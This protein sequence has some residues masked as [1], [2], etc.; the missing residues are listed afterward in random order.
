MA[1]WAGCAASW[2]AGLAAC[3][4]VLPAFSWAAAGL[5]TRLLPPEGRFLELD[6][7]R[8]HVL[9]LGHG[10]PVLLIHGLGG[11]I[12]NFTHSLTARLAGDF[13]LVLVDRPGA[14][15]SP[16]RADAAGPRAQ[17]ALLARLVAALALERPLLVGHSLGGAVALAMALHHPD[18]VGGLA[19]LAPLTHPETVAPAP[20][21]LLAIRPPRLRALAAWT[22]GVPV[23]MLCG[24]WISRRIFAPDVPARN[25]ALAGGGLLALRP[26]SIRAAIADLAAIPG[27]LAAM[28]VLYD[29]LAALPVGVLF[30]RQDRILDPQRHGSA[31]QAR[32]PGCE[33]RLVPG[34]HMLPVSAPDA[35]AALIRATAARIPRG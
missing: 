2:A 16:R 20:F 35:C 23:G 8:L 4:A 17:A 30:G 15:H 27:D 12:R 3:A 9:E 29:R 26:E 33:L 5:A 10:P 34:G 31:L 7:Q 6:G 21:H 13:R 24:P 25:F 14:G 19:L 11:Q 22:L 28:T 1:A 32:L 18:R